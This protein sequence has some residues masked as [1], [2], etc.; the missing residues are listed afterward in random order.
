MGS[1]PRGARALILERR[2]KALELALAGVD[3]LTIGRQLSASPDQSDRPL[4]CG[5][6]WEK[7]AK[8]GAPL[9]EQGLIDAVKM[10]IKRTTRAR[11]EALGATVDE[12]LDLHMSRLE[13]LL[14][15]VWGNAVKGDVPSSLQA[16]RILARE[17]R[18]QGLDVPKPTTVRDPDAVDAD[19]ERGVAELVAEME[20]AMAAKFGEPRVE[21]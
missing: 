2:Q 1:V 14:A 18:L 9:D 3:R 4:A 10:D 20:R 12:F 6:G 16:L 5:Y 21:P 19:V 15:G 11:R 13:R 7:L 17:Q 8:T